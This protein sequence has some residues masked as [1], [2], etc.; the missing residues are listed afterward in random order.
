[1]SRHAVELMPN[2]GAAPDAVAVDAEASVD[3]GEE[4]I[5]EDGIVADDGNAESAILLRTS[6]PVVIGKPNLSVVGAGRVVVSAA[7]TVTFIIA[8]PV[9]VYTHKHLGDSRWM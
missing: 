2:A 8:T 4:E 3:E 7:A 9:L 6:D 1:M 5:A